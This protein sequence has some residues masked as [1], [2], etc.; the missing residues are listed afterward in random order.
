VNTH[1]VHRGRQLLAIANVRTKAQSVAA[2]VFDL[3]MRCIDFRFAA[4]Q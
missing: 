2:T 3:Q 1:A 4:R